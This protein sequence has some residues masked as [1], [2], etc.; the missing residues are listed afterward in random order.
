MWFTRSDAQ[1]VSRQQS[2]PPDTTQQTCKN[3]HNFFLFFLAFTELNQSNTLWFLSSSLK[4]FFSISTAIKKA[5][6]DAFNFWWQFFPSPFGLPSNYFWA[7]HFSSLAHSLI[8]CGD[9]RCQFDLSHW[10][11]TST[12]KHTFFASSKALLKEGAI[13]FFFLLILH[14]DHLSPSGISIFFIH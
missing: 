12:S 5:T 8:F 7:C 3:A 1:P 6:F 14:F 10:Y 4:N 13:K 9:L 11:C 2:S